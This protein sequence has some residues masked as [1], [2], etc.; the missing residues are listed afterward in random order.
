MPDHIAPPT[1]IAAVNVAASGLKSAVAV[2]PK[3]AATRRRFGIYDRVRLTVAEGRLSMTAADG[4]GDLIT[5]EPSTE[6]VEAFGD[7]DV[8]VNA[9]ALTGAVKASG[10]RITVHPD[11]VQIGFSSVE[12]EPLDPLRFPAPPPLAKLGAVVTA[13]A[14]D[15]ARLATLCAPCVSTEETCYYLGGVCLMAEGPSYAPDGRLTAFATDGHRLALTPFGDPAEC[16]DWRPAIL[17][18]SVVPT[19]SAAVAHAAKTREFDG[20]ELRQYETAGGENRVRIAVGRWAIT[21]NPIDAGYPDVRRVIPDGKGFATLA[22]DA[23][24]L[25]TA[26]TLAKSA[27]ASTRVDGGRAVALAFDGNGAVRIR[28]PGFDAPFPG[29]STN[30]PANAV[31]GVQAAYLLGLLASIHKAGAKGVTLRLEIDR[32]AVVAPVL[33]EPHGVDATLALMPIR[34]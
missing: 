10:G 31:L 29:V 30:A 15:W 7:C 25:A 2:L 33:V 13:S 27:K 22:L 19:I 26:V 21:A 12:A 20:L 6:T 8:T 3:A 28:R 11:R 24:D 18:R 1:A 32:G 16:G 23:A 5:W 34:L 4:S 9:K 17:P 14:A